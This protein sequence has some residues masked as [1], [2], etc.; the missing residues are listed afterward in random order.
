MFGENQTLALDVL[1]ELRG[2]VR[3]VKLCAAPS[4]AGQEGGGHE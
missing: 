1:S 3:A 2:T 4:G